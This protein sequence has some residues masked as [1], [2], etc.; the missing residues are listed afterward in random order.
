M[1][2][3]ILGKAAV[4]IAD[5]MPAIN[6]FADRALAYMRGRRLGGGMVA[7]GQLRRPGINRV[8]PR[9]WPAPAGRRPRTAR[10]RP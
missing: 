9:Q 6:R 7:R 5:L 3:L 8:E 2:A 1:A 4:L 10:R